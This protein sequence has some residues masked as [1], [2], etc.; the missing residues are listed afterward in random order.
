MGDD[1][2]DISTPNL[3]GDIEMAYRVLLLQH[4]KTA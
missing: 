3:L 2:R 4:V 1:G